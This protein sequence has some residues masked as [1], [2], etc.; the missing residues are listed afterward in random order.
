[1]R[2]MREGMSGSDVMEVQSALRR[3]G[4]FQGEADGAFGPQTR[5]AVESFQRRFGLAPDGVIGPATWRVLERFLLGYDLYTIQPGDTFYGIAQKYGTT[6]QALTTAN[7]ELH[8]ESL[9]PGRRIV[10]PYAFEDR[11]SVV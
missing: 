4:F 6:V 3:A 10:V 1:M 8:P 7:P 11:K 9:P 2:T 5:G